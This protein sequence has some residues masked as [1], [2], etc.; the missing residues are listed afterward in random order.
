M[1]SGAGEQAAGQDFIE[2]GAIG[3][4]SLN[5]VVAKRKPTGCGVSVECPH[6][7]GPISS[8]NHSGAHALSLWLH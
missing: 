3:A 1:Q 7:V 5:L 8:L 2:K 4:G 6:R